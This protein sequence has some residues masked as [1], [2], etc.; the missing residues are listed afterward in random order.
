MKNPSC[1][2][3]LVT[4]TLN[5]PDICAD[6]RVIVPT[7]LVSG[8]EAAISGVPLLDGYSAADVTG[9]AA[10]ALTRSAAAGARRWLAADCPLTPDSPADGLRA[11]MPPDRL[12]WSDRH[13]LYSWPAEPPTPHLAA[14][15][16]ST[17]EPLTLVVSSG[18]HL[19]VAVGE[20]AGFVRCPTLAVTGG[21]RRRDIVGLYTCDSVPGDCGSLVFSRSGVVGLHCGTVIFGGVRYNAYYPFRLRT[22][23]PPLD[24][25]AI[26]ESGAMRHSGRAPVSEASVRISRE[27]IVSM[28]P[29]TSDL[30]RR[31][32][33]A[34]EPHVK[35]YIELL[36]NPWSASPVRLPDHVVVP[37]AV[38]RFIAN[39]TY[40]VADPSVYG[41]NMLFAVCNRL[42]SFGYGETERP[43]SLAAI[44]VEI[45]SVT[46]ADDRTLNVRAAYEY[47]PGNILRPLQWGAGDYANPKLT[48]FAITNQLSPPSAGYWSDDFGDTQASSIGF[49][50]A[51]RTL[52]MAIRVRIIGLPPGV[53]MTPGKIYFAQVRCDNTDLP[54][55]EQDFVNMEQHGRATHVSAD[56]V[57]EA[58]SKTIFYAPDGSQK[59]AMTSNFLQPAGVFGVGEL[60]SMSS[61]TAT[62]QRGQRCFPLPTSLAGSTNPDYSRCIVP[63]DTS[64]NTV[65]GG[66]VFSSPG[67]SLVGAAR[68]D[69]LD[70]ANADATTYLV[71]G[72]FGAQANVVLEFD[73]AII[74]EYIPNRT[75]PG[76]IE[77]LVQLPSS[78]AMDAIF[79]AAAVLT[80]A[81]PVMLQRPGDTTVAGSGSARESGLAVVPRLAAT[82]SRTRGSAYREGF[83]DFDWLK[84]GNLGPISWDFTD[85]P[86]APASAPRAAP[87]PRMPPTLAPALA[88]SPRRN[89]AA[90]RSRTPV[91]VRRRKGRGFSVPRK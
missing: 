52:S 37:T 59:F 86:A 57:R 63:Y 51:Y 71:V 17:C 8:R 74:S 46:E 1:V 24:S 68:G 16:A 10:P 89:Y 72:Y 53:F 19:R 50:A 45:G 29:P 91:P 32:V 76:A 49:M 62:F 36:M 55:S 25:S 54:I 82:A 13:E 66:P 39:R 22:N 69:A 80:E 40:T 18:E 23:E 47:T 38:A 42:C 12:E 75:A 15:Y 33:T 73:Y 14:R 20:A 31:D 26:V 81:R 58:G 78:T 87:A 34:A 4:Q 28:S 84:S 5:N 85:K 70:S 27:S 3:E 30:A 56:A 60:N 64:G 21:R 41:P 2:P 83:W 44:P 11:D 6:I 35:R 77:A 67:Y 79:S 7:R 48:G 61:P 88:P 43:S 9:A 90:V 65:S